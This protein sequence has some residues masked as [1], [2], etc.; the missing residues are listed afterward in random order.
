[1]NLLLQIAKNKKLSKPVI[2]GISGT[3]LTDEEKRFFEKNGCVGFIIFTRNI[4][5]K[6]QLLALTKSLKELMGGEILILIDQEG[7][8]VT[9]MK[10]PHFKCYPNGEFF[11]KLYKQ[12]KQKALVAIKKN[13][14]EI[15]FDLQ[16]VGI[17]VDC[18]PVLD[19]SRLET[20]QIIGDRAYGSDVSQVTDLGRKVCEGLLSQNV[21]PVIKHIPGH[22]RATCDS[23]LEL[24]KV[25]VSYE[26]LLKTDFA[27][28]KNF[29]DQK[30]AMTA[31][32]L[33]SAIDNKNCATISPK[34]IEIIRKEIG[35]QN[36]LMTDDLSMKALGGTFQERVKLS[37]KAGCDL[38]LHCNG[39]MQEMQEI[40]ASLPNINENLL[41]KLN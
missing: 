33:Y 25:A 39:N 41:N 31:H 13:F 17:N 12:D 5:N 38:I 37:L 30:F 40:N 22:G 35:F 7:G 3:S 20:H 28:F 4:Q 18:A 15:A 23:H 36:I 32:V 29:T 14:A 26:E 34:I 9:R 8:R 6:Q 10:E 2:Y 19:L 11:A 27:V 16:E 1:M 24:P 21:Y